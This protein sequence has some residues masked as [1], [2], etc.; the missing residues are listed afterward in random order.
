MADI[1]A[2]LAAGWWRPAIARRLPLD[3]IA[4]AH[5]LVERGG[6]AG[7]VLLDILA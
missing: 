7:H 3:R 6:A 2:C 5:E 4:E 1:T